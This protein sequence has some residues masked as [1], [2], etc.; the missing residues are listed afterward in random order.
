MHGA[1]LLPSFRPDSTDGASKA[2]YRRPM[3]KCHNVCFELVDAQAAF[4][5]SSFRT[6]EQSAHNSHAG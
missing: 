1:I 5:W 2:C 3:I 4:G 6:Q